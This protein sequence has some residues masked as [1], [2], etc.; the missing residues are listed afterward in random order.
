[1]TNTTIF[2][3]TIFAT[4]Q[5]KGIPFDTSNY[6]IM[7]LVQKMAELAGMEI[8]EP[9]GMPRLLI[10]TNENN[11]YGAAC[12]YNES[13]IQE[14]R[15]MI[16]RDFYIIPSSVHEVLCIDATIC[17]PKEVLEMVQ[18]VNETQ[19]KPED[20]LGEFVLKYDF[21]AHSVTKVAGI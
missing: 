17:S 6:R 7:S 15:E 5:N 20:Q 18:S 10:V 4:F 12:I 16:K 19:V 13:A 14:L 8:N 11:L 2:D 21:I 9:E 3:P 1:M